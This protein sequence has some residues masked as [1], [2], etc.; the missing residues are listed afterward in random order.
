VGFGLAPGPW[1]SPRMVRDFQSQM[2]LNHAQ[3][4]DQLVAAFETYSKRDP[5]TYEAILRP[6]VCF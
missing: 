4:F 2:S 3:L 1:S 6:C 5:Y